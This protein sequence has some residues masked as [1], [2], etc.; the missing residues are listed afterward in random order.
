[1][2]SPKRA[3]ETVVRRRVEEMKLRSPRSVRVRGRSQSSLHESELLKPALSDVTEAW[4]LIV[5]VEGVKH[6][7]LLGLASFGAVPF[8]VLPFEV[9]VVEE[10]EAESE[11]L[12]CDVEEVTLDVARALGAGERERREH[13][14]ALA[15]GVQHPESNLKDF[16]YQQM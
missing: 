3:D 9:D 2:S 14:E 11:A 10:S 15:D 8:G 7:A 5:E 6:G 13:T 16:L 4:R 12:E 1:M